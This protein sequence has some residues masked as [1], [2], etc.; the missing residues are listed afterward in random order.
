MDNLV[1]HQLALRDELLSTFMLIPL[2]VLHLHCA[3]EF[4]CCHI[5]PGHV[6]SEC[7]GLR[8]IHVAEVALVRGLVEVHTLDVC[9]QVSDRGELFVA[10]LASEVHPC[11]PLQDILH[12]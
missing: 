2:L 7:G 10:E 6:P 5:M 3:L 12:P 4:F 9:F 1:V 8:E 11:D